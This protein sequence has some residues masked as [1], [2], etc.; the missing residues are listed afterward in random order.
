MLFRNFVVPGTGTD[1]VANKV[2]ADGWW[3]VRDMPP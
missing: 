2:E 1:N 3:V